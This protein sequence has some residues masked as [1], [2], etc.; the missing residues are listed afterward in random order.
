MRRDLCIRIV[1]HRAKSRQ[2]RHKIL[3]GFALRQADPEI[4]QVSSSCRGILAENGLDPYDGVQDIRTCVSL[5]RSESLDIENIVLR[6]LVGQIS[7]FE[8]CE[9]DLLSC[10]LRFLG[11]DLGIRRYFAPHLLV[12]VADQI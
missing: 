1:H 9:S 5:E 6:G 12:D 11:A 4:R 8:G 7:V 3:L 2:V 10:L